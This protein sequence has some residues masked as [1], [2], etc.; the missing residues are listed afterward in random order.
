MKGIYKKYLD[1]GEQA[2]MSYKIWEKG[3]KARLEFPAL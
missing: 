3:P 1:A 2:D